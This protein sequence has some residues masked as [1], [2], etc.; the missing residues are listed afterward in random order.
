METSPGLIASSTVVRVRR[1]RTRALE[2]KMESQ[3]LVEPGDRSRRQ[4]S[5]T[6]PEAANVNWSDLLCL[7]F[8][9]S[10]KPVAPGSRSVWKGIRE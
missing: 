1:N 2:A 9:G 8:G 7:R 10:C 4:L 3:R 5:H 6:R